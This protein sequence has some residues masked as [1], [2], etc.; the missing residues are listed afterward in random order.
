MIGLIRA[1]WGRLQQT[2]GDLGSRE[3]VTRQLNCFPVKQKYRL[4]PNIKML[5]LDLIQ[6]A[7]GMGLASSMPDW[8][9]NRRYCSLVKSLTELINY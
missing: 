4:T 8:V 6:L 2:D 5:K 3:L 7:A 1:D 9:S